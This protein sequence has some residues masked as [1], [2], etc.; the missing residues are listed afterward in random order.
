M[1]KSELKELQTLKILQKIKFNR[2]D[3]RENHK[4]QKFNNTI[5]EFKV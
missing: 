5:C 1:K 3:F 2:L 4:H